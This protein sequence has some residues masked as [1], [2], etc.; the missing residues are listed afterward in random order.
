MPIRQLLFYTKRLVNHVYVRLYLHFLC[1]FFLRVYFCTRSYRIRMIFKP[2]YLTHRWDP[3]RYSE[4]SGPDN[5][6][7]EEIL[8]TPQIWSRHQMQF[9]VIFRAPIISVCVCV[10]VYG[11]VLGSQQGVGQ[12]I[13]SPADRILSLDLPQRHKYGLLVRIE[14]TIQ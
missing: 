1:S 9:S 6:G 8:Y 3:Y 5:N 4:Q 13:L 7:N 12:R 11:G 14:L 10:C 2:I